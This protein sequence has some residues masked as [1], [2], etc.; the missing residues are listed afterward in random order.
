MN[1]VWRS[2]GLKV[3]RRG[4]VIS[5]LK[6]VMNGTPLVDVGDHAYLGL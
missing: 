1:L 2:M 5:E 4:V 6:G 3:G